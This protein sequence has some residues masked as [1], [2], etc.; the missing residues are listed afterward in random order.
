MRSTEPLDLDDQAE[1]ET[2]G[3]PLNSAYEEFMDWAASLRGVSAPSEFRNLLDL[4]ARFAD[5]P[6]EQYR[7]DLGLSQHTQT[8]METALYPRQ[9]TPRWRANRGG[10]SPPGE[11]AH[12]KLFGQIIVRHMCAT[13]ELSNPS[14]SL[15]CRKFRPT[16]S[17]NSS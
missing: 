7:A 3:V 2:Q 12:R 6:V 10:C 16:T 1:A 11:H 4:L 15:G 13:G 9:R 8:R 5:G 17:S 14:P